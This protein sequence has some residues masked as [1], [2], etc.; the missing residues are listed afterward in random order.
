MDNSEFRQSTAPTQTRV[1]HSDGTRG[2]S[3]ILISIRPAGFGAATFNYKVVNGMP[4]VTDIEGLGGEVAGD[5]TV[6]RAEAWAATII[7]SRVHPNAV[8]R[9]G[10]DDAYVVDGVSK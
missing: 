10:I 6:P 9:L 4:V 1:Q 7:L 5:H 2:Q 3:E 8:I